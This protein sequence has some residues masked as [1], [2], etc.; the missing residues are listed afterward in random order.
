MPK[1]QV[2]SQVPESLVLTDEW[3]EA[4]ELD[5]EGEVLSKLIHG[6][7]ERE[8]A[9]TPRKEEFQEHWDLQ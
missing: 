2:F 1:R 8:R 9:N 5:L 3:E 4:I 6:Q 7:I